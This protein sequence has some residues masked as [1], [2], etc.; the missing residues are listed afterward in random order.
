LRE[1]EERRIASEIA[2]DWRARARS[3]ETLGL[4]GSRE[5]WLG[6]SGIRKRTADGK[7]PI[8]DRRRRELAD[9]TL[10]SRKTVAL[11]VA[12]EGEGNKRAAD[13]AGV[14]AAQYAAVATG[15]QCDLRLIDLSGAGPGP[16]THTGYTVYYSD[17]KLTLIPGPL[18]QAF[19]AYGYLNSLHLLG[20]RQR[21][22]AFELGQLLAQLMLLFALACEAAESTRF[23]EFLRPVADGLPSAPE[24]ALPRETRAGP[25]RSDLDEPAAPASRR[26]R[27]ARSPHE[28]RK[29]HQPFSIDLAA[30]K[31]AEGLC[32]EST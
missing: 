6:Y 11:R 24:R 23:G 21:R 17:D 30:L 10:L 16:F 25:E 26:G 32:N 15:V 20:S 31:D 14:L 13:Y 4:D 2:A 5:E 3:R 28:T 9:Y 1:Q 19:L 27:A 8:A 7:E 18:R 29:Q 22:W 12:F